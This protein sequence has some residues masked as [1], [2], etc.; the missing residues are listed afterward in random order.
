MI[1]AGKKNPAA[2][3]GGVGWKT[4]FCIDD[5]DVPEARLARW[6]RHNGVS[7]ARDHVT[8]TPTE[9]LRDGG[10]TLTRA[11]APRFTESAWRPMNEASCPGAV[12]APRCGGRHIIAQ[13]PRQDG[14]PTACVKIIDEST[15]IPH[16]VVG[17]RRANVRTG[18][19][20]GW[21]LQRHVRM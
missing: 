9:R 13:T 1:S 6:P 17:E 20:P 18:A 21:A 19:T 4:L 12:R 14:E 10:G 11:R 3:P 2:P 7:N 16:V 8:I 15:R 5:V